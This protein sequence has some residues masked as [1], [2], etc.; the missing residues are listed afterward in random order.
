M[1]VPAITGLPS[2]MA[3]SEVTRGFTM[4]SFIDSWFSGNRVFLKAAG[5]E[6]TLPCQFDIGK[7]G[8]FANVYHFGRVFSIACRKTS[9]ARQC[10]CHPTLPKSNL[11]KLDGASANG[12]WRD[13]RRL[14]SLAFDCSKERERQRR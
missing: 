8:R 13:S 4:G 14:F 2:M 12:T 1:R 10:P 5:P 6:P 11:A 7:V 9:C 3:G